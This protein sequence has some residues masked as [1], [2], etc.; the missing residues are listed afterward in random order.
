MVIII[1]DQPGCLGK[2]GAL[3]EMLKQDPFQGVRL[4]D[5]IRAEWLR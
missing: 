5:R 3:E 2:V 1:A 4:L